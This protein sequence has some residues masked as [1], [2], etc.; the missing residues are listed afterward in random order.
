[1]EDRQMKENQ[2]KERT[3][4]SASFHSRKFKGGAYASVLSVVVVVLLVVVNLF[5]YELD[6]KV[7]L[8]EDSKY[9]LTDATKEFLGSIEDEIA[10]YYLAED[11]HEISIITN[12]SD[13][14]AQVVKNIKVT[15]K[16]PVKY[17][18]FTSQYVTDTINPQSS[19]LV[20]N[21]TNGRAKYVDYNDIL[22]TEMDYETYQS[23]V[24]GV[25]VEGRLVSAIQYVTTEDLPKMYVVNGHGETGV[26]SALASGIAKENVTT[27]T[28]ET[29]K[30][31]KVPEDCDILLISYPQSDYTEDEI[32]M[33]KEYLTAGGN[34]IIL[35]DFGFK[36]Q[37]GL[38]GLLNYYGVDVADGYIIEGSS[39]YCINNNPTDLLPELSNHDIT[40]G[41]QGEKYVNMPI[42]S[43]LIKRDDAR[44][45]IEITPIMTTSEEAYSKVNLD[46]TSY[47][48]EEGDIEGP[49]YL[50][51]EA[52]ETYDGVETKILIYSSKYMIDNNLLTYGSFGNGDVFMNSMNYLADV[53]NSL[54]IRTTSLSE[55]VTTMTAAQSNR[56]AILYIVVLPVVVIGFGAYVVIRRRKK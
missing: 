43:G 39:D 26:T 51:L 46:S 17:P 22:I 27:E 21:E 9:S 3:K 33:V 31:E 40:K 19:F 36:E 14:F 13:N 11:G 32:T 34:A 45:S 53:Q 42:S 6:F 24:T 8:T 48:K 56:L 38:M 37:P 12:I 35:L 41:L 30:N 15:Q 2:T 52:K 7:D 28:F 47:M 50:G 4:L 55:P 44:S 1:M 49:F 5:A 16:D 54:S 18:K 10:I 23:Q 25:D 20:V 29:I